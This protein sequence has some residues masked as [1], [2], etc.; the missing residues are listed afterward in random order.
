MYLIIQGG[1]IGALSPIWTRDL[2][3]CIQAP[4]EHLL[5]IL[6]ELYPDIQKADPTPHV[7]VSYVQYRKCGTVQYI[8]GGSLIIGTGACIFTYTYIRAHLVEKS[9]LFTNLNVVITWALGRKVQLKN[10]DIMFPLLFP[11]SLYFQTTTSVEDGSH[12]SNTNG[13]QL[14]TRQL[15]LKANLVKNPEK[16]LLER[17]R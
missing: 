15:E 1:L 6:E 8:I 7:K 14:I 17:A 16:A 13:R 2:I 11:R 4:L 3:S 5:T 10:F 9:F 12:Q